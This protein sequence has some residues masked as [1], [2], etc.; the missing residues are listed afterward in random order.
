MSQRR[1]MLVVS[2]TAK[3]SAINATGAVV[4]A[5]VAHGV[6]PVMH[7]QDLVDFADYVDVSAVAALVESQADGAE[8][9]GVAGQP[10]AESVHLREIELAIVLGGDGTIL[11][12]AE[13]V[14]ET[15]CPIIGVNLGHV[16]F[17]AEMEH[18]DLQEMVSRVLAGDY[19]VEQRETLAVQVFD[20]ANLIYETFA[21]NE[22]TLEKT[23]RMIEIAVGVDGRPVSAFGCD[24]VVVSTATGSTA[25]AFSA[26][27]PVVWPDVNAMLLVPLAAH[28]LFSR[29]LVLGPEQVVEL[30]LSSRSECTAALWSDGRRRFEVLPGQRVVVRQATQPLRMA[31]LGEGVF[32]ERLVSKFQL[33]VRGWRDVVAAAENDVKIGSERDNCCG[34]TGVEEVRND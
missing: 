15:A 28:A 25:Y 7:A 29:P 33:P 12:A 22:A 9:G 14:R 4:R 3:Q 10:G 13:L 24:G 31:R 30:Q 16:G 5:L 6:T 17:L 8:N 23:R 34:E 26:G 21:V 19:A 20:G 27:G 11:R 1:R 32:T 18:S 2:H